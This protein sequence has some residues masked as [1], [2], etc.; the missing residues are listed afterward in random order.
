MICHLIL[1]FITCFWG[2]FKI[3]RYGRCLLCIVIQPKNIV[4]LFYGHSTQ[5]QLVCRTISSVQT[6]C[7]F[8]DKVMLWKK[9]NILLHVILTD[10]VI[11]ISFKISINGGAHSLNKAKP[12]LKKT[13]DYSFC[14]MSVPDSAVA[15]TVNW[16]LHSDFNNILMN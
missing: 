3:C 7:S 10:I 5:P 14:C 11:L 6:R 1:A 12:P 4:I 16:V 15:F 13:T 2:H 8:C 9:P